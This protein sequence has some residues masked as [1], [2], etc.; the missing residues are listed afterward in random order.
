MYVGRRVRGRQGSLL[1][2]PFKIRDESERPEAI[3]SYE[4]WLREK[5]D[6]GDRDVLGELDRLAAL[7]RRENRLVI[8]CWCAPKPCHGDVIARVLRERLATA[9][10]A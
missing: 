9:T 3:A 4:R 1:G 5:I 10:P 6:A 8:T 7:F 2:N